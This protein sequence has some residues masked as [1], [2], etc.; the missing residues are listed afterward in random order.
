MQDQ[1]THIDHRAELSRRMSMQHI[2]WA[3]GFTE[4][5]IKRAPFWLTVGLTFVVQLV[6][7]LT[8]ADLTVTV[9]VM[10]AVLAVQLVNLYAW[11]V[12][13]TGRCRDAGLSRWLSLLTLIPL[14]GLLA[15]LM[16][17]IHSS[18]PD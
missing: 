8:L 3:F 2:V 7:Q 13:S 17:G 12:V 16:L 14:L 6:V 15:V 10:L 5:R 1:A 4:A 9:G 18:K 11:L